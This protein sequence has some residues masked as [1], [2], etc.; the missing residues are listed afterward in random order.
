MIAVASEADTV[1]LGCLEGETPRLHADLDIIS[2][3]TET[4]RP[5]TWVLLEGTER[6]VFDRYRQLLADRHGV[7]SQAPGAVWSSWYSYYETISRTD[8]AEV[9]PQLPALG[10]DTVQI[11]DGWEQLVGDWTPNSKFAAGMR[12]AASLIADHGMR[13]GLWIAPFIALPDSQ[14]AQRHPQMLL[15]DP[16]GAPVRAGTNWGSHYYTFD[17]TRADAQDF[18]IETVARAVHE[19]GFTYLKLD[20]IN[21]GAVDGVRSKDVDRE[22]AYRSAIET[23]RSAVGPDVYLLGSGAPIFA[24]LGVLNAVRTGPDVAPMWDNYATSDP[25]DATAHN[26]VSNA[27]SRLWM[28]GLIGLDPDVVYFRRRRN[29]LSDQQM[30]WLKDSA[31]LSGFPAVSDP[32]AWIETQDRGELYDFLTGAPATQQ[33]DRYLFQIGD[34]RVDFSSVFDEAQS[35]YPL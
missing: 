5:A 28:R 7:L 1:L 29:L 20:F 13:P 15:R 6:A 23:I 17:F 27:V 30:Q 35:R 31:T 14:V 25:S 18:L 9:V 24:S 26:A 12:D 10:F 21:A 3:W 2:G 22:H 32:P 8:L 19:W 34:R 16:N 4:G 33:L 11:D